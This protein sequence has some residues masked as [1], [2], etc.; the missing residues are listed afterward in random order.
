MGYKLIE[1]VTV[2]A[3]G[4]ASIEFT[5]IPQDGVDLQVLMSARGTSANRTIVKIQLNGSILDFTEKWLLGNGSSAIS[6]N[7]AQGFVGQQN[8]FSYTANTFSNN[9]IYI[10][11]YA[12][13][14]PKSISSES[15]TENNATQ[16]EQRITAGVWNNTASITSVEF[17]IQSGFPFGEFSTISLYKIT[18]D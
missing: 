15:V 11:N 5:G 4:V 9:S 17:V 7:N 14:S 8:N 10:S 1:T 18:A 3:G 6:D 16:A 2:G 12:G 13:S